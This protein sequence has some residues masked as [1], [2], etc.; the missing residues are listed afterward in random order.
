MFLNIYILQGSVATICVVC[1]PLSSKFLAESTDK[2]CENWSICG[3]DRDKLQ[4]LT[5]LAHPVGTRHDTPYCEF[6]WKPVS[7][8]LNTS[9]PKPETGFSFAKSTML[10]GKTLSGRKEP[11][12]LQSQASQE[13]W[14]WT[15]VTM[16]TS[17]SHLSLVSYT[18]INW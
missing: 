13:L 8:K 10:Y 14:W 16:T 12:Q 3:E 1:M 11:T 5:F 17:S 2:N 7:C 6:A 18:K 9:K 4:Q 15:E